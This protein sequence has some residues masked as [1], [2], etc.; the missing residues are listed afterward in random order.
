MIKWAYSHPQ[1]TVTTDPF[2]FGNKYVVAVVAEVREKG[3]APLEQKRIE[4]EIGAKQKKK[5]Q[6][7]I[8]EFNK[9]LTGNVTIDAF[10]TRVKLPV[11]IVDNTTFS[12]FSIANLGREGNLMGVLFTLPEG[13]ISKPVEGQQGVYVVTVDKITPAAD[14][15]DYTATQKQVI[16][17]LQYRVDQDLF[18][19]MKTKAEVEDWRGKYY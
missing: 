17:N 16:Q 2:N 14:T 8:E 3:I 11:E 10:S 9:S 6:M 13:K 18:N 12:A 19:A 5:A 15:K 7:F 1:G 4:V